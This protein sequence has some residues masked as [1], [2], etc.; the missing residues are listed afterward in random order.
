MF[1]PALPGHPPLRAPS[2]VRTRGSLTLL[3]TALLGPTLLACGCAQPALPCSLHL[4]AGDLVITEIRGPQDSTDAKGELLGNTRGEWFELFNATD[5]TLDL[6]GLRMELTNL[7]GSQRV[8]ALVRES[9][10]IEPGDHVVLGSLAAENSPPEVD[11]SINSDFQLDNT[12]TATGGTVLL[13]PGEDDDPRSLFANARVQLF[14]CERL[15]D[16][17]VYAQL[18]RLGTYSLDGSQPPT[19]DDNDEPMHWCT[20]DTPAE[21]QGG[22]QGSGTDGEGDTTGETTGNP[23]APMATELGLPGSPGEANPPCP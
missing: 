10:M 16:T 22:T 8:T 17:V 15:V 6:A 12:T 9:L 3:G 19:A 14:A 5:D 4:T 18:P 2:R 11:Y 1:E 20:N 21:E 7:R 13:P 23:D